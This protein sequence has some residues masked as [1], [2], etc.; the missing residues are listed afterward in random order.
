MK[1]FSWFKL[2]RTVITD[3]E[4]LLIFR[5][6]LRVNLIYIIF[7]VILAAALV[8]GWQWW[9][10]DS[11][12]VNEKIAATYIEHLFLKQE[13]EKSLES[14][15]TYAELDPGKLREAD[16]L[17][18]EFRKEANRETPYAALVHL[19]QAAWL[20]KAERFD[21]AIKILEWA[22]AHSRLSL[23]HI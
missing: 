3:E 14:G 13:L 18:N 5:D 12:K 23:I 10:W 6:F 1:F 21:D 9:A 19:N 17:L 20:I 8:G 7:G 2:N 22:V 11:Y 15:L 4:R 16:K